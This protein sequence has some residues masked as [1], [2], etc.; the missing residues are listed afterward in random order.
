[1]A[2]Q[3]L[4]FELLGDASQFLSATDEA[5][6]AAQKVDAS[7][8]GLEQA[9]E[10]AALSQLDY[11]EAA[12]QFV[13]QSG[14]FVSEQQAQAELFEELRSAGVKTEAMYEAQISE[15]SKLS[16]AVEEGS[17]AHQ[18]LTEMQDRLQREMVQTAEASEQATAGMGG[19]KSA[20]SELGYILS[21]MQQ[22]QFGVAEGFRSIGNNLPGVVQE[23]QRMGTS[24][25]SLT[26]ILSGGSGLL[27]GIN[28]VAGALPLLVNRLTETEDKMSDVSGAA[29]DAVSDIQQLASQALTIE[30]EGELDFQIPADRLQEANQIIETR[31]QALQSI[32]EAIPDVGGI[33]PARQFEQLGPVAQQIV[34][35]IQAQTDSLLI[36][37]EAVQGRLEAAKGLSQEL[38]TQV[39][40]QRQRRQLL[41]ELGIVAE[42]NS[43]TAGQ[44]AGA[45]EEARKE[46]QSL[47][48]E[49]ETL[50][51]AE[52]QR[53]TRLEQ[54]KQELERQVELQ[55]QLNRLQQEALPEGFQT[56]SPGANLFQQQQSEQFARNL[57]AAARAIDQ[58]AAREQTL[59][60]LLPDPSRI[61]A[62]N[63]SLREMR[64]VMGDVTRQFGAGALNVESFI[65]EVD[66]M[67]EQ[68]RAFGLA[69]TALQSVRAEISQTKRALRTLIEEGAD[70]SSQA[71]QD[72][73]DKL[74]S[75]QREAVGLQIAQQAGLQFATRGFNQLGRA[76]AGADDATEKFRE[77]IVSTLQTIGGIFLQSA[78]AGP[79]GFGFGALGGVF[80]VAGGALSGALSRAEGGEVR[81][82]GGRTEDQIPAML[83]DKEFVV[84]AASAQMAP[85]ALQAINEDPAL[86]GMIEHLVVARSPEELTAQMNTVSGGGI[87]EV[88]A[89]VEPY[90]EGGHVQAEQTAS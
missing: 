64:Q 35:D 34:Q 27:I 19:M 29:E 86:A 74:E 48:G 89:L 66:Q 9:A 57:Q 24:G 1:M 67:G 43:E 68:L 10:T 79:L 30:G 70:P 52:G 15:L 72:L 73:K 82:K 71:V 45:L 22:F 46:V 21:D 31:V 26:T 78:I 41:E 20:G 44:T 55:K 18:Q 63:L 14:A 56:D 40:K 37:E 53:L 54:T 12:E 83:S 2:N 39:E 17:L 32:Q 33:I 5:V 4:R 65:E 62:A 51:S 76:I 58:M 28:A 50:S 3:Q 38:D 8:E 85:G 42:D 80:T 47:R 36:Q 13:D 60:N 61:E 75:L 16:E 90:H 11:N 88:G 69:D 84:R 23:M 49:L 87:A 25:R 59:N 6:A 77:T 81:G 7:M